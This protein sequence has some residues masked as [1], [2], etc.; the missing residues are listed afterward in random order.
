MTLVGRG[1]G[2]AMGEQ[3][4]WIIQTYFEG[5]VQKLQKLI[6]SEKKTPILS[7]NYYG[8]GLRSSN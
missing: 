1:N 2:W 7:G 5:R 3:K 4:E 8:E 6:A